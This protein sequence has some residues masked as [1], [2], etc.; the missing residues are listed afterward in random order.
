MEI[1]P[2]IRRGYFNA[3]KDNIKATGAYTCR[4]ELCDKE[5]T[6]FAKIN[7]N[8]SQKH[9]LNLLRLKDQDPERYALYLEE[10]ARRPRAKRAAQP[11]SAE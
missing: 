6:Y 5:F 8:K 3:F 11:E 4:C 1:T 2:E 10:T 7:H 9:Q